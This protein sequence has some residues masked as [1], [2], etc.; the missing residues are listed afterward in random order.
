MWWVL[1]SLGVRR[2]PRASRRLARNSDLWWLQQ[3]TE[4][5][6]L[7]GA[8]GANPATA[9][10]ELPQLREVHRLLEKSLQ[11]LFVAAAAPRGADCFGILVEEVKT[12]LT[13]AAKVGQA[14][15][16]EKSN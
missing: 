4:V 3:H 1:L 11:C 12:T 15:D 6:V 9:T 8:G 14:K 13:G 10:V 16:L 7:Q 2:G 5:G